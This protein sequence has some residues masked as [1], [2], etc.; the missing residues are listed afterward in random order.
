MSLHILLVSS[1]KDVI[2]VPS[3]T[4]MAC[5]EDKLGLKI[6]RAWSI[7]PHDFKSHKK[8]VKGYKIKCECG[9]F[10]KMVDPIYRLNGGDDENGGVTFSA[11]TVLSSSAT[12]LKTK[13]I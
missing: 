10:Q 2:A 7:T 5:A 8:F 4:C 12:S 9:Y 13:T 3:S 6:I 11:P 1:T